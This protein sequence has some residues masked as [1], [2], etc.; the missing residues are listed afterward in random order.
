[1]RDFIAATRSLRKNPGFTV[2]VIAMLAVGIGATTA[3]F[4]VADGVLFA[5]LPYA[6]ENRLVAIVN[7]GTRRGNNMSVPDLF[8][9]RHG[10][11]SLDEVGAVYAGPGLLTGEGDPLEVGKGAVSANWFSMLGVRPEIGRFFVPGE[12]EAGAAKVVV[13]NDELWR[14]RFGADRAVLGRTI[15]VDGESRVV[16]GVASSRTSFPYKLGTWIPI[17]NSPSMLVPARRGNRYYQ[18]TARVA[19]GVPFAQ[20]RAEFK[21]FTARLHEVYPVPETGL[22]YDLMPLREQVVGDAKPALL[23]MVAAV[24][25]ILLIACANVAGLLLLRARQRSQEMGIRLALGASPQRVIREMLAESL[26]YGAIGG[27]LGVV[28]AEFAVRGIVA[29]RPVYLPF[30]DDIAVDWRVLTFAIVVTL[31]TAVVFG[32]AP[33]IFASQ[34]D[35]VGALTS[36]TRSTTA[37]KRS[38][39]LRQTFVVFELALALVLLVGAGLLGKSFEKLMAVNTG[40]QP[41]GLMHF[42]MGPPSYP[43]P[44]GA[45]TAADSSAQSRAAIDAYLKDLRAVPGTKMVAAGFG[46]P[47]TG[48][49][50][51]QRGV[52]IDGDAPDIEDRPTLAS[53]KS[54]TPGYLETLGVPLIRGRYFTERDREGAAR[55]AI[56]NEAFVNAYLGRRDPIGKSITKVGEIVGVVGDTKNQSLTEPPDPEFYMPYDQEPV[57]YITVL[58]RSSASPA[59]VFATAR[60]RLATIDKNLPI[61]G[62]GMYD[63]LVR[64]TAGRAEQSWEL[65]AGFSAFALLLAA[66]GIYSVVAFAV[67]ERRREFGI[68]IALGAQQRQVMQLVVSQALRLAALG[69]GIGLVVALATSSV[70]RSMLYGVG[71]TDFTTYVIGCA[72]LVAATIAASLLPARSAARVDPMTVMRSE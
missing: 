6:N 67:R 55:V 54:V 14:T 20:A 36:G 13:I 71:A 39:T 26:V 63:D 27:A 21:T 44:S 72:V 8:D 29:M 56:V 47:F 11:K 24:S 48:P 46:A 38:T 57:G 5:P 33:A 64:S 69:V 31:V 9:V 28:L 43:A 59:S 1:M 4:S 42:D 37:G 68:R 19:D 51:N 50:V 62:E 49:A 10:V 3:M 41:V 45:T 16:I 60:K 66:A 15:T 70:L 52:H 17:T 12:D 32:I 23:V 7:H 34:T 30:V 2:A 22:D 53:W 40:F 61:F 58:V 65:V 18:V 35:L 25:F